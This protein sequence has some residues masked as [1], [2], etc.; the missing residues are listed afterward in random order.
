M[1]KKINYN[2]DSFGCDGYY[3]ILFGFRKDHLHLFWKD[4]KDGTDYCQD[5]QSGMNL[6]NQDDI[7]INPNLCVSDI[8]ILKKR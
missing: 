3:R 4:R 1:E 7:I 2:R 8:F 6:V 5:N